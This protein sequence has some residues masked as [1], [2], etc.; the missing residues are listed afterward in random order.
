MPNQGDRDEKKIWFKRKQESWRKPDR[1]RFA[2][3]QEERG[4]VECPTGEKIKTPED[5]TV[6]SGQA[7]GIGG[8]P[9]ARV[10]PERAP[11]GKVGPHR[12]RVEKTRE[13]NNQRRKK[14]GSTPTKMGGQRWDRRKTSGDTRGRTANQR[15]KSNSKEKK[16]EISVWTHVG[17]KTVLKRFTRSLERKNCLTLQP[18]PLGGEGGKS[19][20]NETFGTGVGLRG[21]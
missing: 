8:D 1:W 2:N 17:G 16:K 19:G 18:S 13:K 14:R 10:S 5:F 6:K 20:K 21:G 9:P 12:A 11:S 7:R 15:K 4:P 3:K